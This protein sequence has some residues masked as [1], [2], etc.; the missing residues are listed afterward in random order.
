MAPKR[1][2]GPVSLILGI[3][4]LIVSVAAGVIALGRITA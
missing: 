3:V 2:I 4:T 1:T